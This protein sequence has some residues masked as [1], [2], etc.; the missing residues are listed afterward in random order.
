MC[1]WVVHI[2]SPTGFSHK[3]EVSLIFSTREA[4]SETGMRRIVVLLNHPNFFWRFNSWYGRFLF[5]VFGCRPSWLWSWLHFTACGRRFW[6]V[7]KGPPHLPC[8]CQVPGMGGRRSVD[9]C[10]CTPVCMSAH[11][12]QRVQRDGS[13][14][15]FPFSS[16]LVA[17]TAMCQPY[18]LDLSSHSS[19]FFHFG[20]FMEDLFMN[21]PLQCLQ[22]GPNL[23]IIHLGPH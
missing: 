15:R 4:S 13:Q 14:I 5:F 3:P 12:E 18:F 8:L 22:F 21:D 10:V 9:D 2:L 19:Q 7:V 6:S 23:V 11:V 20:D 1:V 17:T 16:K